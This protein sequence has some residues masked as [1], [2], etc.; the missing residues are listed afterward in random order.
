M[1]SCLLIYVPTPEILMIMSILSVGVRFGFK[2]FKIFNFG[3]F[4]QKVVRPVDFGMRKNKLFSRWFDRSITIHRPVDTF[5]E[6][7]FLV[8]KK[9]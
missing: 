3:T 9:N 5:S 4:G 8:K 2:P 1:L 6:E 7:M